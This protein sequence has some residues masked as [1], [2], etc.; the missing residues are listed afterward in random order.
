MARKAFTIEVAGYEFGRTGKARIVLR[1]GP[2][3]GEFLTVQQ[4]Q[5]LGID[6]ISTAAIAALQAEVDIDAESA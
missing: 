6:L 4:A 3:T 2:D 1:T 5:Q